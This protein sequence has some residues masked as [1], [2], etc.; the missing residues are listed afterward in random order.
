MHALLCD[1]Y[2]SPHE[3]SWGF[4]FPLYFGL[5]SLMPAKPL[6]F[7]YNRSPIGPCTPPYSPRRPGTKDFPPDALQ[8]LKHAS[9]FVKYLNPKSKIRGT[10]ARLASEQLKS[11]SKHRK[12]KTPTHDQPGTLNSQH[13][14]PDTLKSPHG[15]FGTH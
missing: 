7:L 5:I 13:N 10:S 4:G 3:R 14:R 1:A 9:K 8:T 15:R 11:H 6:R 2:N 12:V